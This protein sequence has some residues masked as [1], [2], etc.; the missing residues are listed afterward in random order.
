M[1]V[2]NTATL[3]IPHNPMPTVIIAIHRLATED[4]GVIFA[5]GRNDS[6]PSICSRS[7]RH[8][9]GEIFESH[10]LVTH[11]LIACHRAIQTKVEAFEEFAH[12]PSTGP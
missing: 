11:P 12:V 4:T 9:L 10:T 1:R 2:V 6:V 7:R 8:V 5:M 3:A